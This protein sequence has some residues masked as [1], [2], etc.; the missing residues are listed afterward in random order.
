MVGRGKSVVM[1]I[2]LWITVGPLT[3]CGA[4]GKLHT[5]AGL[6]VGQN[7]GDE[8]REFTDTRAVAE[9]G[10]VTGQSKREPSTWDYGGTGYLALSEDFR[11]GLK[12]IVRRRFNSA[13]SLDV[14]AGPMITYDSSGLFNGF[15]GGIAFNAS[16][17]TIRSE[18]MTWP[19]EA[20]ESM[21]SDN[22]GVHVVQHPAGHEAVWYNGVSFNGTAGWVA[23]V[24]GFTL[25]IFGV[26]AAE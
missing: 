22:D 1:A 11:P 8:S 23:A 3:G 21:Y 12:L 26:A 10:Y 25:F 15:I 9:L 7:Y 2:I 20:W 5:Q 13:T 18:F 17:L 19:F 6:V 24:V 4:V 16:F 14:S